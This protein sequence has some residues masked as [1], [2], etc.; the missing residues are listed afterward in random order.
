[1][2]EGT[3]GF[4]IVYGSIDQILGF[5]PGMKR[6]YLIGNVEGY[7]YTVK[8]IG[9]DVYYAHSLKQGGSQCMVRNMLTGESAGPLFD[10]IIL[11]LDELDG[12]MIGLKGT[13]KT[14]IVEIKTGK[15]IKSLPTCDVN[16]DRET[17]NIAVDRNGDILY[18]FS[19]YSVKNWKNI[20]VTNFYLSRLDSENGYRKK[21]VRVPGIYE[22][23]DLTFSCG[24]LVKNGKGNVFL[25]QTSNISFSNDNLLHCRLLDIGKGK[26]AAEWEMGN[27]NGKYSNNITACDIAGDRLVMGETDLNGFLYLDRNNT[28]CQEGRLLSFHIPETGE[29]G[30]PGKVRPE[31]ILSEAFVHSIGFP[32]TTNH[33]AC[34]PEDLLK[35]VIKESGEKMV[36]R[37]KKKRRFERC[38]F[39]NKKVYTGD[40]VFEFTV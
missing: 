20:P 40:I 7:V 27:P 4:G 2:T 25:L 5:A 28:V 1:M 16:E 38:P 26:P 11:S 23:K 6:P 32:K 21:E 8:L 12:K 37:I 14:G 18:S 10:D 30:S 22:D 34:I 13:G 9:D 24:Q 36:K 29:S 3:K 39:S 17:R 19:R 35:E 15:T 31:N 33:M